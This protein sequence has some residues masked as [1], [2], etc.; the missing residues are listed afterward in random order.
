[1][2][3]LTEY[4]EYLKADPKS[5]N[6]TKKSLSHITPNEKIKKVRSELKLYKKDAL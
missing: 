2:G 5:L 1:M 3:S 4:F 6:D